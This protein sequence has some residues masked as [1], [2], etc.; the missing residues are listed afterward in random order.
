M[1][2]FP[3]KVAHMVKRDEGGGDTI[4][5]AIPVRFA[6]HAAMH[7][8][9]DRHPRG[10]KYRP[11][12]LQQHKQQW[13]ALC[14]SSASVLTSLPPRTDVGPLQALIDALEFNQAITAHDAPHLIGSP[15][16]ITQC[17]RCM[18]EGIL[19]LLA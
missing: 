18:S 6:C 10:R 11:E 17:T 12:E 2:S 16:E 14:K 19:S 5:N 3:P 9:N 1:V 4:K 7:P 13:L 15:L 8:Y